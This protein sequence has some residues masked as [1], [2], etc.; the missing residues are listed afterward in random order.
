MA[1]KLYPDLFK[2]L[3][4]KDEVQTYYKQFYHYELT[5]NEADN[6]LHGLG[7]DGQRKNHF[8]N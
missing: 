1:Q 6:M 7:P 8:N 5:D 3:K 2:D 4:M